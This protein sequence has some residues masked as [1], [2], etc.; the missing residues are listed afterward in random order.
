[1][2]SAQSWWMAALAF[3]TCFTVFGVVYSFGA[4]FKP[5]AAEF[6][7]TQAFTSAVFAITAAIYNLLGI[8]GGHLT[9]RFGPR[10]VV[11]AAAIAMGI[12]LFATS[13]IDRLGLIYLTYGLGI[14]VGVALSY[15]PMLAV[16]AGWFARRRN[17]ALGIAVSGIGCGTLVFAP[18]A[19]VF[20]QR[21]GWR[22]AYRFMAA[23]AFLC[24]LLCGLLAKAP[25]VPTT[26][27]RLPLLRAA[28]TPNFMVLYLSSVLCS[29]AI[30]TPFVYLPEFA[31]S[32]GISD[33]RAASLVGLIGAASVV[34][35]LALGAVA[36]RTGII[37]L[38]KTSVLILGL[39]YALWML[40][41][42]YL[43]LV[44]FSLVMGSAYGGMVALSPAVVAELF[45]LEGLGGLLGAL[46]TSRP[47]VRWPVRRWLES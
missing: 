9:D 42:S 2:D 14:G 18:L 4:F 37:S 33:V 21:W 17:T 5:M 31:Q 7:A 22:D 43:V 29:V 32:R 24:L 36:D 39:S 11:T 10:P 40:S 35:R 23:G 25:P 6:G 1:M 13:L 47:S 45:G 41:H 38:Y 34:G 15:I 30:Y 8:V 44:L 27:G 20:I 19:A 46:F 16:V 3:L 26:T 28:R 12:G